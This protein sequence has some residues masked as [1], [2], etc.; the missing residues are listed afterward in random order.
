MIAGTRE[1]VRREEFKATACEPF[2]PSFVTVF[3][4]LF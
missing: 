4:T 3:A 2:P 1:M